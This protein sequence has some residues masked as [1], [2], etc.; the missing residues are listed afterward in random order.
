MG[1]PRRIQAIA[2][3]RPCNTRGVCHRVLAP[4][5]LLLPACGASNS[6]TG[7]S[8]SE[9]AAT[10]AGTRGE[11][12]ATPP[13]ERSAEKVEPP[14]PAACR[15]AWADEDEARIADAQAD[16]TGIS[17][18]I[19]GF[20]EDRTLDLRL[21]FET[22]DYGP[23][24]AP[25][26][27]TAPEGWPS[28]TFDGK[29]ANVCRGPGDCFEATVGS[30]SLTIHSATISPEG[31]TVALLGGA[32]EDGSPLSVATWDVASGKQ[33]ASFAVGDE[34]Y[35][36]TTTGVAAL[37]KERVAVNLDVCAGPGGEMRVYDR[38]GAHV[39][40]FGDGKGSSVADANSYDMPL[41]HVEGNR[42]V[43]M[44]TN[45]A[46]VFVQDVATGELEAVIPVAPSNPGSDALPSIAGPM[47]SR[48]EALGEGRFA[49]VL[50][51]H[52]AG[53]VAVI[54]ARGDTPKL[55]QWFRLP[56]CAAA[57]ED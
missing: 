2:P 28:V 27:S 45:A 29:R 21:D 41:F 54:D 16:A 39:F 10:T 56:A 37:G 8:S 49:A 12:T 34:N 51:T 15:P 7:S 26:P 36:C 31:T 53:D 22:G 35:A 30:K 44:D 40:S 4:L 57:V 48:F 43:M 24:M 13:V 18:R 23:R 46:A 14:A 33:T 19:A 1:R 52:Q 32:E 9:D 17:F 42:W 5:L 47:L 11:A 20:P 25:K 6:V 38:K 50:G 3:D 55:Q